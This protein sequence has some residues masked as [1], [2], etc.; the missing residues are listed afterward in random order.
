MVTKCFTT[1]R[2]SVVSVTYKGDLILREEVPLGFSLKSRGKRELVMAVKREQAS[3][4]Q[5]LGPVLEAELRIDPGKIVVDIYFD[6]RYLT[7]DRRSRWNQFAF[8]VVA[9]T[10]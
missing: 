6:T 9:T 8:Q 5:Q 4:C 1:F 3:L 10:P 2:E 7:A